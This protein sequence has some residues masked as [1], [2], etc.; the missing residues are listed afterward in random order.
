MCATLS[1]RERVDA[2][3]PGEG[4]RFRDTNGS[5]S[6]PSPA[7]FAGTL[8][9]WKRVHPPPNTWPIG[10]GRRIFGHMKPYIGIV[11]KDEG[12][13]Y[14]ITFPDAPG[15]FS[16]ADEI[17]DLFAMAREA[18]E[19]WA[20]GEIEDGRFIQ[21]PRGLHAIT[22]DP[23]WTESLSDAALIIAVELPKIVVRQQAAE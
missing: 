5:H 7:C 13:A 22:N 6:I 23:E 16:A 14:G 1:H 20:E 3:R 15:C 21:E 17:D 4:L 2:E 8:S 11:H 12:S 19:L 9:L 10:P 18:L